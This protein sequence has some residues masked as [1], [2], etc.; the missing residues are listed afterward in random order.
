MALVT[1]NQPI[2][3]TLDE[4][5]SVK[6]EGQLPAFV[7]QDH[8]TFVAFL[9]AYYEYMEQ[10]GKP[11]EIVGNLNNYVNLDKTTTTFLE[12]F[13]K[14]F[15]EDIPQAVF[16]NANKPFVLKHL[17]DFYRSK[18]SQKSFQFLFRLLYKEEIDFYFPGKDMLRVSDGKYVK[19]KILRVVD[20]S[21]SD[22]VFDLSG[23]E[24]TG[25]TSGA[26]ALVETILKENIGALVVSTIF[27]SNVVGTFQ[28]NETITDGTLTFTLGGMVTDYTITNAGCGYSVGIAVPVT[29][30]GASSSGTFITIESLTTGFI[31]SATIVSGGS[32]YVVGDK[33]TID[34]TNSFDVD[35]RTASLLVKTIDGSGAITSIEIEH[36]GRDYTSIP[37]VS[38]GGTGTGLSITL[39]GTN[40]G[41]I[42]TL[43]IIN[44]GFGFESNPTLNFSALG[45]GEATGTGIVSSYEN[46]FNKNFIGN[47][48]F[49]SDANYIQDSFYYQLFSYV[50]TSGESITKWRD[51]VKR[52]THPAGLAL[53][54][55]LQLINSIST[56]FSITGTPARRAYTIIFHDGDIVPPV[57]AQMK[58]DSCE[59]DIVFVFLLSEDYLVI[60]ESE[61]LIPNPNEDFGLLTDAVTETDD[62]GLTTQSTFFV[63]P[64]TCQIYEQDLGIQELRTL[65]GF[66]DYLFVSIPY[67]RMEEYGSSLTE[68][69]SETIDFGELSQTTPSTT[70]LRLGPIRRSIERHKFDKQGG[71]SQKINTVNGIDKIYV[72][73]GGSSYSS[74][75]TVAFSGGGGSGAAGTAVLTSQVVT[76][77]TITNIGSG[78]TTIPT[79]AI[80]GGSGSGATAGALLLRT[81]G[82]KIENFKDDTTITYIYFG[83]LKTGRFTNATISQYISGNES[84]ALPPY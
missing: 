80:S 61:D 53:F 17:R 64:T 47:D 60:T 23:K 34:N 5:I 35:W 26:T 32:G 49:L 48:G 6:V 67:T 56:T 51:I 63:A 36:A 82:T 27:L 83:G 66:E 40:V 71:F 11:Y 50:L 45:D 68:T 43:K 30:G 3:P 15:G 73:N 31:K 9:E 39:S 20:T 24:I 55:N 33:L 16:A 13:K 59:G 69:V 2:H 18:G 28:T 38:G 12:Y 22:A 41:G 42:K 4:R 62:Y 19:D 25:S 72:I 10:L 52:T 77:I 37:L 7:K 46:E 8:P 75:P 14:Q 1:P 74:V 29:G 57:V 78:Y 81:S 58:I 79:I 44:N 54:G 21:G 70:Q 76:S 84:T 65:G